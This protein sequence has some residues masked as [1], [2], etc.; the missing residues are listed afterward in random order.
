M[1][2]EMR[3]ELKR[4]Q[5]RAWEALGAALSLALIPWS[6]I[7]SPRSM[8]AACGWLREA[9]PWRISMRA[10]RSMRA[11]ET[12][13]RRASGAIALASAVWAAALGWTGSADRALLAAIGAALSA[14]V[15]ASLLK[16]WGQ[17]GRARCWLA[18][19]GFSELSASI[20]KLSVELD[21]SRAQ[22]ALK[23]HEGLREL[24]RRVA[25]SKGGGDWENQKRA[26]A[27]LLALS[28]SC[29]AS[30]WLWRR[31]GRISESLAEMGRRWERQA[32]PEDE[33]AQEKA[34]A[35]TLL[36]V[37]VSL[38]G[39][40]RIEQPHPWRDR[41]AQTITYTVPLSAEQISAA[42]VPL[43]E[44]REPSAERR[45][46]QT[47][48]W[49]ASLWEALLKAKAGQAQ[50]GEPISEAQTRWRERL[51]QAL[52]SMGGR[53][54]LLRQAAE[55]LEARELDHQVLA[56]ARREKRSRL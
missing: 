21:D 46:W 37:G 31:R 22:R 45:W 39:P 40:A 42:T 12:L 14:G 3:W 16:G 52:S 4:L 23:K 34:K 53:W 15:C 33:R 29:A 5:G 35:L 47:P 48:P 41:S 25:A 55:E 38:K 20:R 13:W 28:G 54:E 36:E 49:Q 10:A 2:Q 6:L 26:R 32:A 56:K 9:L 17:V 19:V 30:Q 51:A 44:T 7:G 24:A 11:A 27:L 50:W 43:L 1:I 18:L 8:A